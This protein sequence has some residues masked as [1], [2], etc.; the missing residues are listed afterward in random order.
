MNSIRQCPWMLSAVLVFCAVWRATAIPQF[1][2][3]D[4]LRKRDW[5]ALHTESADEHDTIQELYLEQNL[6]HFPE[7]HGES[8]AT[9]QQRYFYSDRYARPISRTNAPEYAF[10]CVGGEGP[11]LDKSVLVD[12]VHC[13]G[14]MLELA[15]RLHEGQ[16]AKVHLFALEHRYYGKSYP[17][18]KDKDGNATSPVTN[19]HLIYL[20]SRQALADLAHFIDTMNDSHDLH[21][22]KWI[23]FG[24]SYPGML[25][26]WARLEYPKLVHAAVSN[27]APIQM[28]LDFGAYNERV[29]FDLQYPLVGGSSACLQTVL[30]GHYD[31]VD[32][33][34]AGYHKEIAGLFNV[35]DMDSLLVQKNVAMFVGD[36]VIGIP[37]QGNNP[38]CDKPTCNIQKV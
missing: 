24:G 28:E 14:D 20:S 31:I 30:D 16:Q 26:A 27:S 34:T 6:D 8:N 29:A 11:S 18:F 23:T 13:S 10:L 38:T 25:A 5:Q 9:F 36:G 7:L 12:S 33:I 2:A 19:E 21:D 37:A 15:R 4:V 1:R 3:V 35:C 22:K 17:E 32:A